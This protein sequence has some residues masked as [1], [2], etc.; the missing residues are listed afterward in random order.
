MW[1][2]LYPFA[3]APTRTQASQQVSGRWRI[4]CMPRGSALAASPIR[5]RG[6]ATPVAN[7][8][9]C[10]EQEVP[11]H[12]GLRGSACDP[13]ADWLG[14]HGDALPVPRGYIRPRRA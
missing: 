11:R 5:G 9:A 6:G 8:G 4:L 13:N 1:R 10:R 14:R 7:L 3:E 2:S 12:S